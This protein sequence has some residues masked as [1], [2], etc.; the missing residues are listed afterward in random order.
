MNT[1]DGDK[2]ASSQLQ[3]ETTDKIKAMST[4]NIDKDEHRSQREAATKEKGNFKAEH[5]TEKGLR[6]H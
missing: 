5:T 1:T 3:T 4:E 2:E 6:A